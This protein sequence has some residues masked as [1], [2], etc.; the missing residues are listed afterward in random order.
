MAQT[1]NHLPLMRFVITEPSVVMD[2]YFVLII[3]D[4]HPRHSDIITH[5]TISD[6]V[7]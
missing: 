1:R 2:H 4:D 5:S 3:K 6:I 7:I